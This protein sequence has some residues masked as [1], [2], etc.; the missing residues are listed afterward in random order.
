MNDNRAITV[1]EQRIV[2][3]LTQAY[4]E[5]CFPMA[6]PESGEV[7]WYRPDPRAIIPLDTFR[8]PDNLRRRVASGRFEITT[9]EAFGEVM[10][11]C[12]QPRPGREDTWID[13]NLLG[14]YALLHRAG[15]AHSIEAWLERDGRRELVGGLYGVHIGGLFAGESMFSRPELGGTDASKVCLVHLVR[16]MQRRRLTL[17]DVQFTNTHLEQFGVR[18]IRHTEY[19]KLLRSALAIDTLWVPFEPERTRVQCAR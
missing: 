12:A 16:H 13:D 2:D 19:H 3:A 9:D 15:R 6:D 5:A 7:G 14:W 1:S 8:V 4:S 18:E 17:L 10:R 11:A